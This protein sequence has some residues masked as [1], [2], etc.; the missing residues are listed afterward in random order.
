MKV[1][2]TI[3]SMGDAHDDFIHDVAYDF[4]GKRMASCSSDRKSNGGKTRSTNAPRAKAAL[5]SFDTPGS[6]RG[7]GFIRMS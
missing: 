2:K 4:Y 7:C 6:W 5:A 1:F 3:S